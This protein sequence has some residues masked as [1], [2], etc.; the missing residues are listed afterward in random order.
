MFLCPVRLSGTPAPQRQRC[1]LCPAGT[2]DFQLMSGGGVKVSPSICFKD[3]I[4]MG[5][6]K[7]CTGRGINIAAFDASSGKVFG[8]KSFDMW[9]G[10]NSGI[11]V[12]FLREIPNVSI[13]LMASYDDASTKLSEEVKEEIKKLGSVEIQNIDFRSSWVF[14]GSKGF[15]LPTDLQREKI[16]H[17][18]KSMDKYVGWPAE[19]QIKGC[20]PHH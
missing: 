3:E 11:M 8:C 13:I 20:I 6:G 18:D 5:E 16:N 1:N 10:D 17:S 7:D 12:K 9:E 14:V 15:S 19:V 4:I 2:F